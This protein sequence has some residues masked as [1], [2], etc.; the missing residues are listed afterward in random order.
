MNEVYRAAVI[1]LKKAQKEAA[2]TG[3]LSIRYIKNKALFREIKDLADEPGSGVP[4]DLLTMNE[5]T[6]RDEIADAISK[7]AWPIICPSS[8]GRFLA[9]DMEEVRAAKEYHKS[10]IVGHQSQITGME[11]AEKNHGK[12]GRLF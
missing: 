4:R 9:A 8:K 7:G 10:Y 1:I 11:I 6:M 3:V 12:Q 2:N 5:R